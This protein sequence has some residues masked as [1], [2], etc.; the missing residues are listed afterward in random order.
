MDMFHFSPLL[1][2]VARFVDSKL[3]RQNQLTRRRAPP[4]PATAGDDR[5]RL[6]PQA[7]PRRRR[8]ER[9]HARAARPARFP[10]ATTRAGRAAALQSRAARIKAADRGGVACERRP[11]PTDA[12]LV[13]AASPVRCAGRGEVRVGPSPP[14]P[15]IM[16]V[17]NCSAATE[18]QQSGST[19]RRPRTPAI[20]RRRDPP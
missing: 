6:P 8:P 10:G 2:A 11:R 16:I 1:K 17:G 7:A 15:R 4:C 19:G 9:R 20:F 14:R 5:A 13:H 12:S 18:R 3:F